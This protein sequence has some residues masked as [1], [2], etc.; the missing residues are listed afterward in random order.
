MYV[1]QLDRSWLESPFSAHG[2][3]VKKDNEIQLL[4]KFCKYVYVDI[5]RSS[6]DKR[7]ILDAHSKDVAGIFD[8][9][10]VAK[11]PAKSGGLAS[12][13]LGMLG[14]KFGADDSGV[15]YK[16]SVS[17]GKEMPEAAE[18]YSYT[19]AKMIE[20]LN[21]VKSN[22]GVNVDKLKDAVHPMV[23]SILRNPDAMAWQCYQGE[24]NDGGLCLTVNSAV[25]AVILGRHL[26]LDNHALQSL[27]MGGSMLDLGNANISEAIVMSKN[28]PTEREQE[29]LSRHV[30]YGVKLMRLKP[31]INED[32]L[33]MIACHHERHDGS[34]YPNGLAGDEIPVFG[35]IAG[36]VNSYDRSITKNPNTEAKSSYE[37]ICELNNLAG[38][39]FHHGAVQHFVKAVGMFPTGS[40]VLLN[41]GEVAIVA[42]QNPARGLRP[43]LLVV[44]D[45]RKQPMAT[46][47]S[48]DLSRFP[49]QISKPNARW[50]IKGYEVGAFDIDP[51]TYVFD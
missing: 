3:E 14:I 40:F 5:G 30:E 8:R 4:R 2:F 33:S 49:E 7:K 39:K 21:E 29:I 36:L 13:L 6:I 42:E 20:V 46:G 28:A 25:W 24:R 10:A 41:T 51:K 1:A 27:A 47:K 34:G 22:K 26:G 23:D 9:P 38:T 18:A 50:I 17:A 48:V 16:T 44:L 19:T 15:R 45:E 37:A 11:E 32:I 31:G 35:R 43:K 12:K